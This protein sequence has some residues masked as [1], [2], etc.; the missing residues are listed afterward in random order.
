MSSCTTTARETPGNR[1]GR[2]V[3]RP[4]RRVRSHRLEGVR[5]DVCTAIHT[6]SPVFL[7]EA[8]PDQA[9]NGR[10]ADTRV[11]RSV[12]YRH[13][14]CQVDQILAARATSSLHHCDMDTTNL[15]HSHDY[16]AF[17]LSHS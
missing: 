9:V 1:E 8:E 3:D 7:E 6:W 14:F 13:Q 10:A 12:V 11:G 16:R 2:L 5:I 15:S 17:Y 4:Q